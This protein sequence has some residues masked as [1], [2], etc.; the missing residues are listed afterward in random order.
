MARPRIPL[1]TRFW[2]NVQKTANCWL[3]TGSMTQGGY[4][5]IFNAQKGVT[6]YAHRIAWELHFGTIPTG[7]LVCHHCDNPRCVRPD[8]LFL[9]T[10]RDNAYDMVAKRRY[11][12]GPA[13]L[14]EVDVLTIRARYVIGDI[15]YKTLADQYGVSRTT[16]GKIIRREKWRHI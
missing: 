10:I 3:W 4:G 12:R 9:G 15:I 11:S 14:A 7:L 1:P 13:K 16:I 5:R 2:A 6:Q 8:H